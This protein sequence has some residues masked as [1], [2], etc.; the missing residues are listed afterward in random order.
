MDEKKDKHVLSIQSESA[1]ESKDEGRTGRWR[2]G[3]AERW[4]G[5]REVKRCRCVCSCVCE[6]QRSSVWLC[7]LGRRWGNYC[8][9]AAEGHMG[10]FFPQEPSGAA[11]EQSLLLSSKNLLTL[12]SVAVS[13]F[14]TSAEGNLSGKSGHVALWGSLQPRFSQNDNLQCTVGWDKLARYSPINFTMAHH[15][16]CIIPT[17]IMLPFK[18]GFCASI[19]GFY[20]FFLLN[21]QTKDILFISSSSTLFKGCN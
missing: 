17:R 4:W 15:L 6:T 3:W 11:G 18:E 8:Q 16:C 21:L 19:K 9:V 5:I 13:G 10:I 1:A 2:Q 12:I 14:V 20:I 7:V